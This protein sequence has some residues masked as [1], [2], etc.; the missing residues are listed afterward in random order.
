MKQGLVQVY[1]GNGKGKTTSAFGL[2]LRA[3]G[4]GL[5]VLII[6][7]F[8]PTDYL[9]GETKVLSSNS[10]ITVKRF[11]DSKI[12]GKLKP[13]K[14]SEVS[15]QQSAKE[16]CEKAMRFIEQNLQNYDLIIL[17]EI[18]SVLNHNLVNLEEI[19]KLIKSKPE[20][21][22]I[23][24]TGRNMPSEVIGIADLVSEIQEIRHPFTQGIS[25][26]KGIEF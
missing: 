11:G 12:W 23:V 25:A 6:Q 19:L 22:E 1:T 24:L 7:F 3:S 26:R 10:H 13:K 18:A 17:D 20:G 5:N 2:A 21:T 14:L 16:E 9:S 15:H 4:H 8:K